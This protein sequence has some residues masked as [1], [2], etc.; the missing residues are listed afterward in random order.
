[1]KNID[2]IAQFITKTG[3]ENMLI[4]SIAGT[5]VWIVCCKIETDKWSLTLME[6][7]KNVSFNLG[8]VNN[9]QHLN[10]WWELVNREI[11]MKIKSIP[12][13]RRAQEFRE[14]I[15]NFINTNKKYA[16][17]IKIEDKDTQA[18]QIY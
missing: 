13:F 4:H 3:G 1:M 14:L 6:P 16:K 15:K 9:K 10:L 2:R 5:K 7:E 17:F 11:E 18:H 8:T 12:T